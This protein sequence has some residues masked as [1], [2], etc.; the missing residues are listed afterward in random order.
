MLVL[1]TA[2]TKTA[3]TDSARAVAEIHHEDPVG[4]TRCFST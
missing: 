1:E 3:G 2:A 4:A